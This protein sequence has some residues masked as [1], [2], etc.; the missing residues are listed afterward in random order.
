MAKFKDSVRAD[1]L[2]LLET[3]GL[4]G[5]LEHYLDLNYANQ[6]L[7]KFEKN[8]D[9]RTELTKLIFNSPEKRAALDK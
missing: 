9:H 1:N 7:E 2:P 5:E 8:R 6:S 3:G 4:K